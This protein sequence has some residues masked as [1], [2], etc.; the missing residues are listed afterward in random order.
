MDST[1]NEGVA[2]MQPIDDEVR[3]E[4]M[5]IIDRC[6]ARYGWE[7]VA[8]DELVRRT[9]V[10]VAQISGPPSR[11]AVFEVY[12][13]ALYEACSGIEG[14]A[15]QERGYI[16]LYAFLLMHARR[17]YPEAYLDATQ[18]ALETIYR[19]F[20]RC[21]QP[22]AFLAFAIQK[23][24]DAARAEMR[25]SQRNNRLYFTDQ[26]G[27]D[28][29]N[30]CVDLAAPDAD[31]FEQATATDVHNQLLSCARGFLRRHPR[32]GQQLAA[33]W[34]KYIE[35][36]D[37]QTIGD[38]LG[39]SVAHVHVLRSRAI[40]SLRQDPDWQLLAHE[41]GLTST[42]AILAGDRARAAGTMA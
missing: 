17:R 26:E 15:R 34:M 12:T 29:E 5:E 27:Y 42:L 25:Q 38:Q 24:R 36:L 21:R 31:P 13:L 19:T 32:A 9:L 28:S 14:R 11:Q 20:E 30:T 2:H 35:G 18:R 1:A 16:E 8:R 6:L 40:A 3:W 39:K 37:D 7:L 10:Q 4:C 33:L 23:L 22:G 41:I